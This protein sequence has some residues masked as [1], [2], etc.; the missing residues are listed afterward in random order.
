MGM[1]GCVITPN[2]NSQTTGCA[3]IEA[4]NEGL[5]DRINASTRTGQNPVNII[6][7]PAA[8]ARRVRIH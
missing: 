2:P 3:I 8:G 6:H 7:L 1:P 5:M 4:A